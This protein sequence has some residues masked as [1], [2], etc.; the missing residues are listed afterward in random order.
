MSKNNMIA[1]HQHREM[2]P[3]DCSSLGPDIWPTPENNERITRTNL[4]GLAPFRGVFLPA[5]GTTGSSEPGELQAWGHL[6]SE[7]GVGNRGV[8]QIHCGRDEIGWP[9]TQS[10][11]ASALTHKLTL[12][13][14]A[15]HFAL[16][17]IALFRLPKSNPSQLPCFET[18]PA[19]QT[20]FD[21]EHVLN[22]TCACRGE[23]DCSM[24]ALATGAVTLAEYGIDLITAKKTVLFRWASVGGCAE[25][26][27]ACARVFGY[28]FTANEVTSFGTLDVTLA[29]SS[30][31]TAPSP[32]SSSPLSAA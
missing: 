8:R 19:K 20:D 11:Y 17:H 12:T 9:V 18:G 24:V 13:N 4:F 23:A 31:S 7:H 2:H 30:S 14:S 25:L 29:L 32:P 27:G 5:T 26:G 16:G 28:A 10:V 21:S 6:F 3:T 22:R 1:G 15:R